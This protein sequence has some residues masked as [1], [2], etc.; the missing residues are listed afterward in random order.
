MRKLVWFSCGAASANAAKIAVQKYPDCEVLYC[1]TF[2]YEHPDNKRF[3]KDVEKWVG[4]KIK[5]LR[6]EKYADIFEVFNSGWLIGPAG[7]MC[8]RELKTKVRKKYQI[9]GDLHIFGLTS[10]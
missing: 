6:S 2:K 3:F 8:T 10:D 5:V 9:K 4:K 7:A 1:D